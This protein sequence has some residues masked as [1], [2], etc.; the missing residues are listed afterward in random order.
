MLGYILGIMVVELVLLWFELAYV[1]RS[2]SQIILL[3]ILCLNDLCIYSGKEGRGIWEF[4]NDSDF[5]SE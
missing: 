3:A 2:D 4:C 5:D 1:P